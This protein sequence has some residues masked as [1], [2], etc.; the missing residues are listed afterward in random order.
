[1]ITEVQVEARRYTVVD[2]L[3]LTRR[4]LLMGRVV[5][6]L[7]GRGLTC[8]LATEPAGFSVRVVEGGWYAVSG[9]PELAFPRRATSAYAVRLS[10]EAVGYTRA[11]TL[12]G[13]PAGSRFPLNLPELR[14]RP[15]PVRLQGRVTDE[16]D[17]FPP[18]P[19]ARVFAQEPVRHAVLLRR[20]I[21][22]N[23]AVGTAVREV[24]VT[25]V[26]VVGPAKS[27]AAPAAREDLRV[28][29]NDRQGVLAGRLLRIGDPR[30]GEL[31][32]IQSVSPNPAD[33]SLPGDVVLTLPLSRGFPVGTPCTESAVAVVN[34]PDKH[35]NRTAVAGEAMV[36]LDADLTASVVELTDGTHPSEYHDLGALTDADGYYAADG[37]GGVVAVDM[38][39]SATGF[40]TPAAPRTVL[41][42]YDRDVNLADW[43]L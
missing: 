3:T 24:Q 40:T 7:T 41:I 18:I 11:T 1:M 31:A 14:L 43:R 32:E 9:Y 20:P 21:R 6:E 12:V 25:A 42:D 22:R 13:I 17:P 34:P 10:V 15:L 36:L 27:L 30:L 23:R 19:G 29:L 26:A 8:S 4:V 28:R 16:N 39:V 5:D 2:D 33:L 37:F 38:N 35:C